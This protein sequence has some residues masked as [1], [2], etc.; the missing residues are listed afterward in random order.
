VLEMLT[1]NEVGYNLDR[2]PLM[3][4]RFMSMIISPAKSSKK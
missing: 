3:E 4:G 1:A 2:S